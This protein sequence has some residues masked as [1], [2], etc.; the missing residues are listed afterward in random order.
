MFYQKDLN[1]GDIN[2]WLYAQPAWDSSPST[3]SVIDLL[4]KI[5]GT[6]TGPDYF[7]QGVMAPKQYAQSGVA[8]LTTVSD[9]FSLPEGTIIWGIGG[10]AADVS[11]APPIIQMPMVKKM[12]P[13]VQAP[14]AFVAP[15]SYGMRVQIFERGSQQMLFGHT[16]GDSR[17]T[18]GQ[19]IPGSGVPN[20]IKFMRNPIFVIPPGQIQIMMTNLSQN[21]AYLQVFL[22][23]AVPLVTGVT[24]VYSQNGGA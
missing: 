3:L 7:F 2:D 22:A 5:E 23:C 11:T 24:G 19:N 1:E 21:L 16:Y 18:L 14:A 20:G 13:M 15:T 4:A 8:G 10:Y 6:N 12:K 9:E 17:V